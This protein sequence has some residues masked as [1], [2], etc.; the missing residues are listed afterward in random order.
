MAGS[1]APQNAGGSRRAAALAHRIED[2][3]DALAAFA[4]TLSDQ[5]WRT[6]ITVTDP[7]T[8]GVVVH[9]VASMYPIEV[10]V[11]LK[12]AGGNAV[13]D[14]TWGVVAG[15]NAKHAD[16]HASATKQAALELLVRNSRE[17]ANA[18]R[19]LTDAQLDTALPFSLADLAPTTA[20]YVIE[21]HALKH[22]WH[23]LAQMRATLGR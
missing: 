15:I 23:H 3:A 8:I 17:A 10:D 1:E 19:A 4:K 18:I 20:Q 13:T 9:H 5:E 2:G 7:R 14:V 16:E 11:A 6:R 22:P 12:A 21:D